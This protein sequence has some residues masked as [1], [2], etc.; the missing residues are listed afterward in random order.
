MSEWRWQHEAKTIIALSVVFLILAWLTCWLAFQMM[1]RSL[2]YLTPLGK[3][4]V[5]DAQ[6]SESEGEIYG[7]IRRELGLRCSKHL[8]KFLCQQPERRV[9]AWCGID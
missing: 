6:R 5:L 2:S 9:R 1:P 3:A 7:V 8:S 4:Q